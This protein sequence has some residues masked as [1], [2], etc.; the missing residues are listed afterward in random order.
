MKKKGREELRA[1]RW[2]IA[3]NWKEKEHVMRTRNKEWK[4]ENRDWQFTKESKKGQKKENA[5]FGYV[6][7]LITLCCTMVLKALGNLAK[8]QKLLKQWKT[9]FLGWRFFAGV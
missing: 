7:L 3:Q 9:E 8:E 4:R 2:G 1:R 6:L 5:T